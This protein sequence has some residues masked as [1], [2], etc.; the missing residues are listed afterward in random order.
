MNRTISIE[1]GKGS[2]NHNC[3]KF[4]AANIDGERTYRNV[5]Y[6]NENIQTVYHELFDEALQKYNDKQRRSD[7][8]ISS[9]YD[10]IKLSKQEKTF[11]E[12]VVQVGN[13]DDMSAEGDNAELA[14]QLLDEYYQGFRERNPYLRVFSAHLHMDEATPHL[15]IDFVPFTTNSKQ[16]LETRVSMKQALKKQGFEGSGRSQTEWAVWVQSEKECLAQIMDRHGIQ[17]EQKG[18]HEPHLSVQDFKK[19]ERAKE[20]VALEA[21]IAEKKAEFKTLIKQVDNLQDGMEELQEVEEKLEHDPMYSLP[22]PKAMM[23]AKSYKKKVVDPVVD[24]LKKLIRTLL[25]KCTKAWDAYHQISRECS[26]LSRKNED[27]QITVKQLEKENQKLYVQNTDYRTLKNALGR[28]KLEQLLAEA[29][30]RKK[31]KAAER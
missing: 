26:R 9:Y 30:Q 4:K 24:M 2:V 3:R 11:H 25:V 10:K 27:L 14:K 13:K 20:V 12:I 29:K 5:E 17:W 31:A 6:C 1:V 15:H 16:G 22:E 8:K 21:E 23:S 19:Q 18:T 7:R 28:R